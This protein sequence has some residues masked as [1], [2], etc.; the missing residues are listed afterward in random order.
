LARKG[1]A[2]LSVTED[3]TEKE[4]FWLSLTIPYRQRRRAA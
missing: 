3:L 2:V 1:I 4:A